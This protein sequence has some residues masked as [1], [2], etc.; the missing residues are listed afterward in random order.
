MLSFPVSF[1]KSLRNVT[2]FTVVCIFLSGCGLAQKHIDPALKFDPS[3]DKA[4][5][6]GG[7]DITGNKDFYS[8][9]MLFWQYGEETQR[10]MPDGSIFSFQD[11]IIYDGLTFSV[12]E[13]GSYA[14][15]AYIYDPGGR[16][17]TI[18]SPDRNS[19]GGIGENARIGG[20]D[21]FRFKIEPG[22]ALYLGEF[23]IGAYKPKW[24]N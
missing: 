22:Q 23:V 15:V 11:T 4:V 3:N 18:N 10:L 1:V 13:P 17:L 2:Y 9:S 16:V 19:L 5:V 7:V 20:V 8:A 6:I 21:A 12:I 14:M 24:V